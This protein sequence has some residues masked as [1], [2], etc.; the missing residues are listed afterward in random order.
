MLNVVREYADAYSYS[1]EIMES[2]II[3]MESD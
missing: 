1:K 2:M 3:K